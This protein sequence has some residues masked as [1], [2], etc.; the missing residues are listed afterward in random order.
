M[1]TTLIFVLVIVL[2]TQI[3]QVVR[4]HCALL[5]VGTKPGSVDVVRNGVVARDFRARSNDLVL[6][7]SEHYKS[8][9]YF[10]TSSSES[11]HI[12]TNL[13]Y[14]S[15]F[16]GQLLRATMSF[17]NGD[18]VQSTPASSTITSSSVSSLIVTYNCN[19]VGGSTMMWLKVSCDDDGSIPVFVVWEKY[20]RSELSRRTGISVGTEPA[21]NDVVSNG[22]VQERWKIDPSVESNAM[23]TVVMSSVTESTFYVHTTDESTQVYGQPRFETDE[24]RVL[25]MLKQGF[26]GGVAKND[27]GNKIVLEYYCDRATSSSVDITM[28]LDLCSSEVSSVE[29]NEDRNEMF[30]PIRVEWVKNCGIHDFESFWISDLLVMACLGSIVFCIFRCY[31]NYYIM[32][33]RGIDVIPL[34]R[35]IEATFSSSSTF[36]YVQTAGSVAIKKVR[37]EFIGRGGIGMGGITSHEDQEEEDQQD[38]ELDFEGDSDI[39]NSYQSSSHDGL[40]DET[41]F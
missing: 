12:E 17:D 21:R 24:S 19:N 20:C 3:I 22:I 14:V 32:D 34:G 27:G 4:S 36:R 10:S 28:I 9:F 11:I 18:V 8:A 39:K 26:D 30:E 29:C 5:N 23:D 13:G 25:V 6:L 31:Y 35:K 40:L 7:G 2:M 41:D 1:T 38:I 37:S 16:D 33:M 15:P